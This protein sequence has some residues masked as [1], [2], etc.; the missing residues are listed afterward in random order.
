MSGRF[1]SKMEG[2]FLSLVLN[3]FFRGEWFI[4]ALIALAAHF[5]VNL[6][7]I[8]MWVL[9]G[10]WVLI[11][12]VVTLVLC[13]VSGC[14]TQKPVYKKNVNPYSAKTEDFFTKKDKK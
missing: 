1:K 11:S 12:L 7:I 13:W 4:L 3:M 9:L 8:V 5:A 10:L 14:G 6:P 2:F